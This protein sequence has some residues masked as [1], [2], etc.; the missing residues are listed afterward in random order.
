MRHSTRNLLCALALGVVLPLGA[1][2]SAVAAPGPDLVVTQQGNTDSQDGNDGAGTGGNGMW[3][4]LGLTGLLGLFGLVPRRRRPDTIA[5]YP[6]ANA[7]GGAPVNAPGVPQMNGYPNAAPR[8]NPQ[9]RDT[10]WQGD[11]PV[12][13]G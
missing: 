5:R 7:P 2:A 3:G 10:A 6:A 11:G 9:V 13:R 1:S 4:L 12:H 8:G